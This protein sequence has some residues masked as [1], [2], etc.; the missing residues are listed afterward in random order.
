MG[1]E[2]WRQEPRRKQGVFLKTH[3]PIQHALR[4][5]SGF[6]PLIRSLDISLFGG[7]YS[8]SESIFKSLFSQVSFR[9]H[10]NLQNHLLLLRYFFIWGF[11]GTF[12]S[13]ESFC[14]E[15]GFRVHIN[16]Q[17][18]LLLLD[19]SIFGC[20]WDIFVFKTHIFIPYAID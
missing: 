1:E 4:L 5:V 12:S 6:K 18:H 20:F 14:A 2:G 15:V 8:S 10:I 16:P 3:L 13:S 11:Q 7:F 19:I 17:N 9:V